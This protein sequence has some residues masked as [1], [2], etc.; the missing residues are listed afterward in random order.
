MPYKNHFG[1]PKEPFSEQFFEEPFLSVKN[2]QIILIALFH[3][4]EPYE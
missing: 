4:K 1:T 2:I 3:Y